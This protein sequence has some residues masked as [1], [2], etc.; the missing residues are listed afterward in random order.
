M[1][2]K[3]IYRTRDL[4]NADLDKYLEGN[5]EKLEDIVKNKSYHKANYNNTGYNLREEDNNKVQVLYFN[6]K[7][8]MNEV[9][10]VKTTGSGASK[11]IPKTD[12]FN[13]VV[14]DNSNFEKLS[15][16]IEVLSN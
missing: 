3:L 9:Y 15:K 11:A 7:T 14:D 2:Q 6:Y 1:E 8:Y 13:P 4:V 12:R 16:S 5:K 10:K